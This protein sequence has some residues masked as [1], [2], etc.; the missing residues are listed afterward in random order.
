VISSFFEFC[1]QAGPSKCPLYAPTVAEIQQRVGTIVDSLSQAPI[2]IPFQSKSPVVLTKKMIRRL[3]FMSTYSPLAMFKVVADGLIAIETYNL[4]TLGNLI[5][6]YSDSNVECNCQTTSPWLTATEAF[7]AIACGDGDEI[8]DGPGDYSAYFE[9]LAA[10]SSFASQ[11]WGIHYLQCAQW[12]IRPK[13]RF[14]GPLAGNTSHPLLILSPSFD[15]VCPLKDARAV[16][17]RYTG[18]GLL[19]QN[20]YGHCTIASPS[21]C[22]AKR[23]RAYFTEGTLPAE[24]TVCEVEELPFVGVVSNKASTLSR[25]DI[26]L[27]DALR[28]LASEVPRFGL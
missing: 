19:V 4:T 9:K 22:T 28:A 10:K 25:A 8:P 5:E 7:Y 11:I 21:L 2:P 12:K 16:Q 18:S 13:S 3:M 23:L 6:S 15:P 27:L 26:E 20:S 17:R 24:G 14:M 1:H